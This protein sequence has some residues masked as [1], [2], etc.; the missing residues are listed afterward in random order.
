MWCR[1]LD[2]TPGS[3]WGLLWNNWASVNRNVYGWQKPCCFWTSKLLS[4]TRRVDRRKE[5]T[6]LVTFTGW[7]AH[8]SHTPK[9]REDHYKAV[10]TRRSCFIQC[11]SATTGPQQKV[12]VTRPRLLCQYSCKPLPAKVQLCPQR[13]LSGV[14]QNLSL[15]H[16]DQTVMI[17]DLS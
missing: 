8:Y 16:R 2:K 1:G 17:W 9:F 7:H 3:L 4:K 13:A 6:R 14:W 15:W 11:E 10:T 12:D 5:K